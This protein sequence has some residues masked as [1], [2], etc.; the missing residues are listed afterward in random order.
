MDDQTLLRAAGRSAALAI[1]LILVAGIAIALFF[2]GRGAIWG[3]VNDVFVSLTCLALLLPIVA[4]DRIAADSAP[5]MRWV[6][7][8]AV[9]GCV[10][11]AVGQFA[12]VLG[13]IDLQTSFVTGGVGFLGLLAWMVAL[14]VLAL[15]VGVLPAAI[16]WLSAITLA[17]VILEAAVGLAI[18]GPALWLAS[19]VLIVGIVAWLGAIGAGLLERAGA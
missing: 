19:L 14:I 13:R 3:P 8:V 5:W 18:G 10:L 4:I 2:G 12:L 6:S 16:G 15:A 7:L 9:A 17:L 1:P 11:I